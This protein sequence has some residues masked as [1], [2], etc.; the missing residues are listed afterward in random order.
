MRTKHAILFVCAT[1]R[2]RVR[3]GGGGTAA[4][5]AERAGAEAGSDA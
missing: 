3:G 4:D 2:Q 1:C 5:H